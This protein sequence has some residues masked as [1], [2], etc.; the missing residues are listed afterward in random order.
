MISKW[1]IRVLFHYVRDNTFTRTEKFVL[2]YRLT[3]RTLLLGVVIDRDLS[4]NEY[5]SLFV[6]NWQEIIRFIKIIV[7]NN[8]I[9]CR[10]PF[11]ILPLVCMFH[12]RKLN[13][14]NNHIYERFLRIVCRDYKNPFKD[15]LKK[16]KSLCIHHR[17]IQSFAVQLFKVKKNFQ[18][19]QW[20]TFFLEEY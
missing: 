2:K 4:F 14:K 12:G 11:R 9:V 7:S 13:R 17:K 10:I 6:K 19:K 1:P 3:F 8:E 16:D 15:L 18:I 5:V 20:V